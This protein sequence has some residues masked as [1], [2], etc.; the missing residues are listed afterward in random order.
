MTDSTTVDCTAKYIR[1]IKIEDNIGISTRDKFDLV[2]YPNSTNTSITIDL[3]EV[4]GDGTMSIQSFAGQEVL[5]QAVSKAPSATIDLSHLSKGVYVVIF[6][7]DK[8]ISTEK[9]VVH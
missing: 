8:Y 6:Q 1:T 9:L 7:S 3:P 2:I 4:A 5:R